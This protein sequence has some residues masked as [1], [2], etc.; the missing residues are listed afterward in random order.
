MKKTSYERVVG[1]SKK[2]EKVILKK[3]E[4][5]FKYQ[6]FERS[7]GE[8]E[9]SPEELEIIGLANELSNEIRQ[10]YGL[11]NFDI[12]AKNI[13]IVKKD[14]K[15]IW[16]AEI[17]AGFHRPSAQAIVVPEKSSHLVFG[18]TV[19]HEL[20]HFKSYAALQKTKELEP[21]V[22]GYRSGLSVI[23]RDGNEVYFS[24]LNEAVT[25]EIVKRNMEKISS[26]SI[27]KKE[28]DQ[29]DNIVAS[30]PNLKNKNNEPIFNSDF[31][32]ADTYKKE[33]GKNML[34]FHNFVYKRERKIL[35]IL[36]DKL[37]EKNKEKFHDKDEIFDLFAKGMMTGNI[38]PIGRL[39][40][41]SF[42]EGTFRKIG[43]LDSDIESLEKL[44]ESL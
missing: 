40:E 37:L 39:I 35:N 11:E 18:K 36:I 20:L 3:K 17:V 28:I 26:K 10:R 41:D 43:E 12:P 19:F 29:S 34:R 6:S 15:K 21:E 33:G 9:K 44:I 25:E 2:E 23:S 27:F 22:M 4:D 5:V 31:F 7:S 42:G 30:Y 16:Q 14:Q 32:Y 24:R 8:K 1:V 38:L 13:H